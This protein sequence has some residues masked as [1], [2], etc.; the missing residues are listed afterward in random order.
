VSRSGYSDDCWGA[1]LNLWR[2]SVARELAAALDAMPDK[3]LIH[4]E[5]IREDG[6]ACAFG[7]VALARGMV[8]DDF[9]IDLDEYCADDLAGAFGVARAM[10]AEIMWINDGDEFGSQNNGDDELRWKRVRAW[11][12]RQIRDEKP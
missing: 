4:G 9:P 11:V 10:A 3:R 7:A 1:E 6:C 12:E 8:R 2:G 5:V